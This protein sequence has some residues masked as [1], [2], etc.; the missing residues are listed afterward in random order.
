MD[1]LFGS[2]VEQ[3]DND[4]GSD[5]IRFLSYNY[6]GIE[7]NHGDIVRCL[8]GNGM[9]YYN[10]SSP[11][12]REIDNLHNVGLFASDVG[13]VGVYAIYGFIFAACTICFIIYAFRNFK[14]LEPYS[15]MFLLYSTIHYIMLWSMRG[16]FWGNLRTGI[17]MYLMYLNIENNKKTNRTIITV[18]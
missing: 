2:F 1:V 4:L 13:I 14:Y 16:G 3:T 9:P 12:G 15:R 8:I 17:F 7:W 6:F 11:Y 18:K 10:V 5:Y